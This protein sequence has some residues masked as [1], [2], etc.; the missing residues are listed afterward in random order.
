MTEPTVTGPYRDPR[1]PREPLTVSVMVP[2]VVRVFRF[3]ERQA[4]EAQEFADRTRAEMKRRAGANAR[5]G[6]KPRT[7]RNP[8]AKHL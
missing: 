6:T 1:H 7:R 8:D 3:E 5:G 2:G 4:Y